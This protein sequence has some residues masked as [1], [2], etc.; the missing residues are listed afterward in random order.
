MRSHFAAA[1]IAAA[2]LLLVGCGRKEDAPTSTVGAAPT[3]NAPSPTPAPSGD[4]KVALVMSGPKSDNGWNSGA[5]KALELVKSELQLSDDAVKSVDNQTDA[6][7]QAKSLEDFAAKK[8]TVVFGHG[9]EYEAPALK[10]ESSFPNTLFVISA[11]SKVGKNTT[12]IIVRL[13]DG[14]YLEGMLAASMSK[15]NTIASV[16][17]TQDESLEHVFAAFEKGAKSVNPKITVI[18]PTYTGSWDDVTKAKQQTLALLN[19]GADVI[20]QDV[21]S[22]AKG[23][24]NAVEEFN[25]SGKQAWAL[26]TNGDQNAAAP[27]VILASAPIYIEKAFLQIAKAAKAGTFKPNN[28]PFGMREGVV[29]FI[30][31]PKLQPKIAATAPNLLQDLDKTRQSIK[32]G[33]MD[34]TKDMP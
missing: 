9:T 15:T 34:I 14:A 4:F 32:D 29:D 13:E 33:S 30:I 26:G 17:A 1:I 23:V 10:I 25:K 12:P 7:N 27:D 16:G 3:S 19:R 11:G 5:S 2:A 20:M 8:F 21:D 24:F 6:S 22:A 18:P 28:A 31:N